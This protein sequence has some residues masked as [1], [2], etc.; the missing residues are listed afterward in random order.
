MTSAV[1]EVKERLNIEDVI[2][3]YVQL[4]RSGRN[5]KGLSPFSNEKT[6]SFIVSPEKQIW[7][8][9]S[10]GRGGNMFSFVMEMEGLDFKGALELLARQAGVDL[11]KYQSSNSGNQAREKERLYELMELAT[12][13]YQTH[14]TR[15]KAA[16][17]Y[18]FTKRRFSKQTILDFQIGYAP[19]TGTA[20]V[21]FL[22]KKGFS[23]KEM[24]AAGIATDR[25][26]GLSDMF[27]GR[28]M[29]PLADSTGRI[30]GFTARQLEDDNSGPKYINTPQT[31]LYDKGRH[32]FGLHLAKEAIRHNDYAV[33][34]EG[35]LDVIA[36]HQVGGK[37]VVATAGT[38]LTEQQLKAL[39]RLTGNI[40]LSFDLDNAGLKASERAI[41]IASRVG[42]SLYMITIP[43]GKDPDELIKQDPKSWIAAIEKPKYAVDWLIERYAQIIDITT[44]PGKRQFTDIIVD[45]VS[46][47]SDQVEKEHYLGKL[48]DLLGVTRSALN[49][50]LTMQ[51]DL[52][53]LRKP[54]Q[55]FVR[56]DQ[57]TVERIKLQ[58]HFLSLTLARPE[59]RKFLSTISS[60]MLV[61]EQA[62]K[63]FLFLREN[64]TY[65]T[66]STLD[67]GL[68]SV[69]DYVKILIL[70]YEE[71]YAG[72]EPLELH[73]E[74][75]RLQSQLI[76]HYV[77]IQKQGLAS[78]LHQVDE[79]K[80]SELLEEVRQLD[81]L[82]KTNK[83]AMHD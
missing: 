1:D 31:I 66:D 9:F 23:K 25:Y 76:Q 78:R 75:S 2:A 49:S 82:L 30:I 65:T 55:E 47:L 63:V 52:A 27:R 42:V 16:W 39:S 6:A 28:I 5:F 59:L 24:L 51:G 34:V 11:S 44:G 36:S 71:L 56:P 37:Q 15:S 26:S 22:T 14:L 41:P 69:A 13:F 61:E 77:K 68:Q 45:V 38:A 10:S 48:A 43:S 67:K 79:A 74:A 73:Y 83:G 4:K 8:D 21:D 3:Q 50:K 12:K 64:P 18:V 7:H 58:D 35:N 60:D 57:Q 72:L 81:K 40:R 53:A 20:L 32:I 70:Q 19:N 80:T 54:K 33:I 17:D 29:I 46:K 62:D